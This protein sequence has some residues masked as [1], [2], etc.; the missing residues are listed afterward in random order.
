MLLEGLDAGRCGVILILG[1]GSTL[2]VQVLGVQAAS[3]G[4]A[5]V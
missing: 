2:R 3:L 4:G 1:E 5:G